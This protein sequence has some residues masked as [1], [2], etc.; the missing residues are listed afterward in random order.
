LISDRCQIK[1]VLIG[2]EEMRGSRT[3]SNMAGIINDVL[4]TYRIE[5]K[6]PGSTSDSA[7]NNRTLSQALNNAWGL[8]SVQWCQL[9]NHIPCMAHFV[10]LILG[11]FMSAIKV[12]SQDR[13]MPSAFKAGYIEKVMRLDMAF[14]KA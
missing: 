2:F 11:A 6:I 9:E 5:D 13:H 14:T 10:L 3:G 1:E 7:R 4:A 12:K 8:K